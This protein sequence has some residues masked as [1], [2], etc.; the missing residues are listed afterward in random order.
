VCVGTFRSV[1]QPL[2]LKGEPSPLGLPNRSWIM[3]ASPDRTRPARKSLH[4]LCLI[5][6]GPRGERWA[7]GK[8]SPWTA[9]AA[10]P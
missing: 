9:N 6:W 5:F 3:A 4:H 1:A 2:D 7:S 8:L 10:R